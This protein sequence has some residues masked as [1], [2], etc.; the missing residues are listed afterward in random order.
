MEVDGAESWGL[1]LRKRQLKAD[2]LSSEKD[3]DLIVHIMSQKSQSTSLS[4]IA[5]LECACKHLQLMLV[6][7]RTQR[8]W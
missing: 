7:I 8:Q 4:R 2:P 3:L 6:S 5:N 1:E